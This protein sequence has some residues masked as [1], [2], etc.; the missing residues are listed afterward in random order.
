[1]FR[2]SFIILSTFLVLSAL[3]P[4][5]AALFRTS[6]S[7]YL[8]Q[9][10]AL[11]DLKALLKEIEELDKMVRDKEKEAVSFA[12]TLQT[13]INAEI[14][15]NNTKMTELRE[16]IESHIQAAK[17]DINGRIES[18]KLNIKD[19][20]EAKAAKDRLASIGQQPLNGSLL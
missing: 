17:T 12:A 15:K 5:S 20:R 8:D 2:T 16:A 9:L 11:A 7:D 4:A 18:R 10:T 1:M 6:T 14:V 19:L 13:S 3:N